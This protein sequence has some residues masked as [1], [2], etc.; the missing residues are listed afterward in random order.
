MKKKRSTKKKS[1]SKI[2]SKKYQYGW[3]A[4]LRLISYYD[5]FTNKVKT[6]KFRKSKWSLIWNPTTKELVGISNSKLNKLKK[7]PKELRNSKAMKAH[8]KFLNRN[9]DNYDFTKNYDSDV[10]L[11]LKWIKLGKGKQIDYFSD[12][13]DDGWYYYYHEFGEYEHSLPPI[14]N[15]GVNI[16]YDQIN[17][18]F[19]AKGGKL[20]VTE[21]GIIY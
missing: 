8:I 2:P 3:L 4:E 5:P 9:L 16:Y 15:H 12:K 14:K 19:R 21:R 18:L 6:K 20:D 13:F 10:I 1:A 11:P 17:E 7:L